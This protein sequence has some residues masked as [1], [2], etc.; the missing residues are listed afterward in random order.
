MKLRLFGVHGSHPCA[1]V[2]K[3]LAIKQ[4]DYRVV[5]LPAGLHPPVMRV[6]FGARTVPALRMDGERISGSRA[7]MH[8]L[9]VVVP[10]PALY[11]ADAALKARVEE[12][13]RWGDE[14]FQPIARELVWPGIAGRPAA[15]V[16]YGERARGRLP[17]TVTR[18]A[19]PLIARAEVRL[20][21]TS[22]ALAA[23]RM[24]ELPAH[25]DRID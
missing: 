14:V 8:R 12:A 23:Q 3:A 18:A 20:N 6:M 10:A 19:A 2:E 16:S 21:R 7:I 15:A 9:D 13:D 22:D 1:A 4:L 11:P 25:L 17:A 5:E 24:R